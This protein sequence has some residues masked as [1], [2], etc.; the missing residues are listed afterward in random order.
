M[1][2]PM[3]LAALLPVIGLALVYVLFSARRGALL[4]RARQRLE[5]EEGALDARD[6]AATA[7]FLQNL[8]AGATVEQALPAYLEQRGNLLP[9][10]RGGH[11]WDWDED[12]AKRWIETEWARRGAEINRQ[13]LVPAA[14]LSLLV[15]VVGGVTLS[16]LWHFDGP[17][18]VQGPG[19]AVGAD[20]ATTPDQDGEATPSGG[21]SGSTPA[22]PP[23]PAAGP[24][25][26]TTGTRAGR[27]GPDSPD[28][29]ED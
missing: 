18:A 15:L 14:V 23:R 17:R 4:A 10:N 6:A 29:P 20:R 12:E 25:P 3:T 19:A 27:A 11:Q 24:P 5:K 7:Q 2:I 1:M 13:V 26:R 16:V 9:P 28:Q 22:Q 8:E 21:P